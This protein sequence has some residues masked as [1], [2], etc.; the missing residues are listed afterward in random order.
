VRTP[1]LLPDAQA[2][3][4]LMTFELSWKDK[5]TLDKITA[6][7]TKTERTHGHQQI[8]WSLCRSGGRLKKN[9][10]RWGH[11]LDERVQWFVFILTDR[12]EEVSRARESDNQGCIPERVS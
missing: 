8:P 12:K 5:M 9:G 10:E 3:G 2:G 1:R 4:M 11:S 7:T 6:M